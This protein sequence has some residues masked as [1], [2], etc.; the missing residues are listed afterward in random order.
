MELA[1]LEQRVA[2]RLEDDIAESQKA[3]HG[4]DEVG[5]Q[6]DDVGVQMG[7]QKI[8]AYDEHAIL[9]ERVP[10]TDDEVE[11]LLPIS[12]PDAE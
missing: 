12:P 9:E 8:P 4:R 10:A 2:G 5:D 3:V 11:N 6:K 7:V 1:V